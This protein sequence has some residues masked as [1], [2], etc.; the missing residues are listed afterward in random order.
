MCFIVTHAQPLSLGQ[1][2][3]EIPYRNA[4]SVTASDNK[5]YCATQL[6]FYSVD[7]NDHSMQ[8]YS[9]VDGM[10]D[11]ETSLLAYDKTQDLLVICY[12]NSNMDIL[13]NGQFTNISD[14]KRAN[15]VGDKSIYCVY[16]LGNY[17]YIGCG[18]GIVVL[19][20]TKNEIKDTYYIGPFGG[21]LRVNGITSDDTYLYA[22]T[23]SGIY[24]GELSDPFLADFSRW[25]LFTGEEGSFPGDYTDAVNFNNLIL[26]SKKDTVFQFSSGFWSPYYV[27][28]GLDIKKMHAFSDALVVTHIGSA[29]T[30]TTV[31]Y[32]SGSSDSISTP[33]PY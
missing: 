27:R 10:S 33:Q 31:L 17:A 4:T 22:A 11:I 16:F 14:I 32:T 21:S 15:I 18:F 2:R 6:S 23:A 7:I 28:A 1:W 20:V 19:D 30:R 3:S 26:A 29:G 25:H 13:K 5:V 12:A 8:P 9:K 24:R